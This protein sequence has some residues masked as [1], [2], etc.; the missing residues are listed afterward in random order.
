M[1]LVWRTPAPTRT[2]SRSATAASTRTR[3]GAGRPTG[4]MAPYSMPDSSTARSMGTKL[5]LRTSRSRLT[6]WLTSARSLERTTQAAI[7]S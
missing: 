1:S 3:Q 4:V 7:L 5:A 2:L 6:T